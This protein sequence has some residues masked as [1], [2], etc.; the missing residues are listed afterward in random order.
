V[1]AFAGA[2]ARGDLHGMR[3]LLA[4]DAS[5]V[6]DGGGKVRSFDFLLRGGQRLAQ[7]YFALFRRRGA[8]VAYRLV[9]VNGEPGLARFIDGTLESVQAFEFRGELISAIHVQRNPDKLAAARAVTTL[10]PGSS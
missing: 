7:L 5:L 8:A 1:E 6:G 9:R 3:A 4:E 10:P 2:A